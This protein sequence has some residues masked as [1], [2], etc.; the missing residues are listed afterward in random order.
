MPQEC[1]GPLSL[2]GPGPQ[3]WRTYTSQERIGGKRVQSKCHMPKIETTIADVKSALPRV[4]VCRAAMTDDVGFRCLHNVPY[5]QTAA[6]ATE[7]LRRW[8][9]Q[10]PWRMDGGQFHRRSRSAVGLGLSSRAGAP[11]PH[12]Q[13]SPQS[14][15]RRANEGV[16]PCVFGFISCDSDRVVR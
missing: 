4:F 5:R 2:N 8:P 1:H 15:R 11:A 12:I 7:E 9:E 10:S 6:W 13:N 14:K 3:R 16:P